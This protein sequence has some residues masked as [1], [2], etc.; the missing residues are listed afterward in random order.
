MILSRCLGEYKRAIAMCCITRSPRSLSTAL[1]FALFRLKFKEK[2]IE[3]EKMKKVLITGGSGFIGYHLVRQLCQDNVSVRCLVRQNSSRSLLQPFDVEYCLG[4]L[5]DTESLLKAVDGC[6]TIF[7]AA[8]LVRA[9]NYRE[10]ETVNRFG[11][12][13]L[14]QV[15]AQ[16]AS[17]PVFVYVSSLSAAGYAKPNQPKRE[18]DPPLPISNYGKSKLAGETTLLNFADQ[19]PCTIVRPGIVFGEADKMNFELFQTIKKIGFCPIPG[20][21]DKFYSWIHAA[22]LCELLIAAAKNG[23]RLA[24][25]QP[26]GTGIYF[27]S[28]DDGRKLS[29][30]GCLIGRSFGKEHVRAVRCPP[31]AVWAVST[32]YELK[33]RLT[34]KTQPFDW[35]K[36]W[37]SLYH[38]TCSPEKACSQL[39]FAPKP[40]DER[41]NQTSQWFVENGWG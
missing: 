24:S 5:G 29:E 41:I 18:S 34:S 14:A 37:E 19:M 2:G 20:F 7:H 32:Y 8:G 36:A 28:C 40:L 11:T 39:N 16:S 25:N 12:E 10:F 26:I 38:W 22:D 9:R 1:P 21:T 33:M 35:A 17:P 23:E 13:N 27:A 30:I 4:E 31:M 3:E 6:D 15:A